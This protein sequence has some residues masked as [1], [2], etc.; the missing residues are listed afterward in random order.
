M[1]KFEYSL[2]VYD[3]HA[4]IE[5]WVTAEVFTILTNLCRDHGFTLITSNDGCPGFKLVKKNED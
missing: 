5:G 3:T 4:L 1:S 2:K